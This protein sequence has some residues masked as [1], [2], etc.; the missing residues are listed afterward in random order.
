[1]GGKETPTKY[2]DFVEDQQGV[3]PGAYSPYNDGLVRVAGGVGV[4]VAV[5]AGWRQTPVSR[6][7]GAFQK[8][9]Y[10]CGRLLAKGLRKLVQ[11][12]R[13]GRPGEGLES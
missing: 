12:R 2:P 4:G 13:L 1:M 10:L 3:C 8:L 6:A 9:H 5:A 11:L 7:G